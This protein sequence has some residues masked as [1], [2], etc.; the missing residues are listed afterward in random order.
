MLVNTKEKIIFGAVQ[1]FVER[2]VPETT[3]REIALCAGVAEG[4]IYRYFPSK[5]ELAW[6]IFRD[7]HQR[8]AKCLKQSIKD[9][10]TL[11]DRISCLVACFFNMADEDW[12]MFR[13]YL[14]AQHMYM[15]KID[16]SE[17]TPYEVITSVI[18]QSSEDEM[19]DKKVKITAA[20][21]M[22]AVH[23]IAL[24]K[25]YGRIDGPLSI[26]LKE[27]AET[28]Y[29]IVLQASRTELKK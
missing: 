24:N 3:T 5:E 21:A 14:T 15:Q 26:Y 18:Y 17:A 4:S 27:V 22:G 9:K 25:L 1:M 13:Y 19:L 28:V 29:Q 8:L 12:L 23:Q 10:N 11:M 20:M 16:E 6:Q 2:G 7:Y